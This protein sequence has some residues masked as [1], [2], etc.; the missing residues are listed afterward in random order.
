[1]CTVDIVIEISQK[2]VPQLGFELLFDAG[3]DRFKSIT[4]IAFQS[5]MSDEIH[6]LDDDGESACC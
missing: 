6:Y 2:M 4:G 1:M 3:N 5:N